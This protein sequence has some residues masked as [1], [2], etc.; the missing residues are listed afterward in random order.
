MLRSTVLL[1]EPRFMIN[2]NASLPFSSLEQTYNQTFNIS[3][4]IHVMMN[5][6]KFIS[7]E[8]IVDDHIF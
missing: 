6:M 1:M 2:S 3:I 7:I 5:E 8:F 4:Y